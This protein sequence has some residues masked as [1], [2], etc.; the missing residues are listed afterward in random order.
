[1]NTYIF[2]LKND[3]N[4]RVRINA[5]TQEDAW[6]LLKVKLENIY[7]QEGICLPISYVYWDIY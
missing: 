2:E 6:Y 4:V 5:Q 3:T 1:M 7:N